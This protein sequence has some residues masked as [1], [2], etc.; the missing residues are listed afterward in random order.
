MDGRLERRARLTNKADFRHIFERP[1]ESADRWF[2]VLARPNGLGYPR[3]GMAISRKA[4]G[5]AVPRNRIKRVIR[6]SFRFCQG[7]L[8]G[9]DIIVIGRPGLAAQSNA[10]LFD[11]LRQH[12]IRLAG[13]WAES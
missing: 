4:A 9:M 5:A 13:Q 8:G 3:L 6:E 12:W 1:Y 7:Q 10:L 2:T 11:S